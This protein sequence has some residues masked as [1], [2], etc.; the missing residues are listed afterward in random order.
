[1]LTLAKEGHTVKYLEEIVRIA[2][3]L[4]T[5]QLQLKVAEIIQTRLT[6]FTNGIPQ[7]SWVKWFKLRHPQLIMRSSEALDVNSAKTLN[8]EIVTQ[9]YQ[10]LEELYPQHNYDSWQMWDC[11]EIGTQ[12]NKIGE[13]TII[14]T[15]GTKNVHTI[16][17]QDRQWISILVA[18]NFARRTMPNYYVFKGKRAR[19]QFIFL[20]EEGACMGM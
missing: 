20:C 4:N 16:I 13:G 15:R 12:A 14:V 18:I 19:Q 10:N 5:N 7:K 1:M 17:P 8:I 9:F 6:P 11:D 3:S 2:C